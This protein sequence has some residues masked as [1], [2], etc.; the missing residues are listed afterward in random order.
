MD[1]QVLSDPLEAVQVL[2]EALWR[3][4]VEGWSPVLS[5]IPALGKLPAPCCVLAGKGEKLPIAAL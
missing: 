4:S 1:I 3:G 2:G 5:P